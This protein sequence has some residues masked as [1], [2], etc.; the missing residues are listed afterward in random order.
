MRAGC[1]ADSERS[2]EV[3][4]AMDSSCSLADCAVMLKASLFAG[5]AS[6]PLDPSPYSSSSSSSASSATVP[7]LWS[8]LSASV[9]ASANSSSSLLPMVGNPLLLDV[10]ADECIRVSWMLLREGSATLALSL[11]GSEWP[12]ECSALACFRSSAFRAR[13]RSSSLAWSLV[14]WIEL[15]RAQN[16]RLA[17][18]SWFALR[19][20]FTEDLPCISNL[21][22]SSALMCSLA[23]RM[24]IAPRHAEPAS[25][26]CL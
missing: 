19:V 16:Q 8:V 4:L 6:C 3:T 18:T 1:L 7:P 14:H 13:W 2:A 5:G 10:R 15:L 23:M 21:V 11:G 12:W 22:F 17:S 25:S 26:W 9:A 20:Y 24:L